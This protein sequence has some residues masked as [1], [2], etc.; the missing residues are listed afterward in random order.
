M[1]QENF[2]HLEMQLPGSLVLKEPS[3]A[4]L[5]LPESATKLSHLPSVASSQD[6]CDL[7]QLRAGTLGRQL[8]LASL[9]SLSAVPSPPPF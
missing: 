7:L 6:S 8:S 4:S 1:E 2:S 5:V 9:S 3:Q